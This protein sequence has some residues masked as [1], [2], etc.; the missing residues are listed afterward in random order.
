MRKTI[1]QFV[2]ESRVDW[3][4]SDLYGLSERTLDCQQLA[5][6]E[7]LQW[8]GYADIIP[9]FMDSLSCH[10]DGNAL[11][12]KS[13]AI[14]GYSVVVQN[15][16]AEDEL[17]TTVTD[18]FNKQGYCLIQYPASEASFSSYYNK[19]SITH[20]ALVVGVQADSV[21][22]MDTT[23]TSPYFNGP[24]GNV[25]WELLPLHDCFA[26][27]VRQEGS[28][29]NWEN[30]FVRLVKDSIVEMNDNGLHNLHQYITY[31]SGHSGLELVPKLERMELE[32]HSFR[33]VRE[34][35]NTAI[36][37]QV[38]PIDYMLAGW[39]EEVEYLCKAWS[40]VMGV[41]MKWKRQPERNY[42]QKLIDYL[43]PTYKSEK[44]LINEL[45][46]ILRRWD[47]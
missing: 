23:G 40:L 10:F 4:F 37:K 2:Q 15:T 20:W 22:L 42:K 17:R 21:T 16:S 27:I 34:L 41:L 31:I 29:G 1:M 3:R 39:V 24:I 25:P 8:Q 43:L 14:R 46:Q 35:W 28:P 7:V 13:S 44:L 11:K 32:V 33:Q 9:V 47:Y 30:D 26:A 19:Y 38:I 45:E 18:L 5:V 36:R 12:R 6:K